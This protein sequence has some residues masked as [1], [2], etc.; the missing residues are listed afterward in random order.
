MQWCHISETDLMSYG[1]RMIH[2]ELNHFFCFGFFVC[3]YLFQ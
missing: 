1:F 2:D 3:F